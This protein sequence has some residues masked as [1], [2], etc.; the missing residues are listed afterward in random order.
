M[1]TRTTHRSSTRTPGTSGPTPGAATMRAAVA[2][3][4]GPPEVVQV[5][6][7]DRPA[8]GPGEVL[9]RVRATAVTVADHRMRSKEVPRGM[10]LA[11]GAF[12]G[13]RRPRHPI[14]GTDAAGVVEAV[15]DGVTGYAPGDEVLVWT[16]LAGGCHAEFLTVAADNGIV[17]APRGLTPEESAALVFGASTA[18]A[19]LDKVELGPGSRV[20]VN[21]ASGAVGTMAVQLAHAAGAHVTGVTSGRNADLVRGLGADRVID[22]TTTDFAREPEQY[23]VIVETVG[24]APY[25]R[26]APVLRR[27]G[28]LLL[29]VSELPGMVLA[30]WHAMRLHGQVA[31]RGVASTR[32]RRLERVVELADNGTLRPVVDRVY[33]FE[34]VV[35]AHRYVDTGRKRGAVVLRVGAARA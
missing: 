11:A 24:N 3:R 17:H 27:G 6:E 33:A 23:D 1:S 31:T 20:L 28:A 10:G 5:V 4:F 26:V 2:D 18:L 15:G 29:V 7:E 25:E 14:L 22:Y 19:F 34:E 21:G 9:V 16:G 13:W 32:T 12:M 35:E 30:R 8:P